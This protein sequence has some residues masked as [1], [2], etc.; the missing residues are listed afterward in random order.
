MD[1]LGMGFSERQ[2]HLP[3]DLNIG[4]GQLDEVVEYRL[5]DGPRTETSAG[6]E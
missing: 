3:D 6:N 5:V 2:A 1:F 4:F